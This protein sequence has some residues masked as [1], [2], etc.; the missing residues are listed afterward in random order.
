LFTGIVEELGIVIRILKGV[1]SSK[2]T[3]KG[4]KVLG[5][6]HIGDSISVNGVCLT[7]VNT[8]SITFT[9]DIMNETLKKTSLSELK[10]G[11]EVNLE[12]AMSGNGRFGGHI[13]SGHI[14]GTGIITEKKK[15]DIAVWLKIQTSQKILYYIIEKGSIAVDGVSLTVVGVYSDY[16]TVS[17]IPHTARETVILKKTIGSKVNLECDIVGKYIEKFLKADKIEKE[18]NI[19]RNFL[20]NHGF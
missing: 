9:A 5:D 2:I 14:D 10:E 3:L 17:V 20:L 1:K 6:I 15:D 19:D 16:F 12:R 7:V 4:S 13:V 11:Q 8:S 18:T